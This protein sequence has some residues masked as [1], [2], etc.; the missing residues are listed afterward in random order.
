MTNNVVGFYNGAN[1]AVSVFYGFESETPLTTDTGRAS[2]GRSVASLGAAAG[3]STTS[4]SGE[5]LPFTVNFTYGTPFHIGVRVDGSA[6][7]DG[8]PFGTNG[9]SIS[10]PGGA[11]TGSATVDFGNTVTWE[12]I[13]SVLDNA[14]QPVASYTITSASGT[15]YRFAVREPARE[16]PLVAF[17]DAG[18]GEKTLTWASTDGTSYQ[19]QTT[20]DLTNSEAWEDVGSAIPATTTE[21]SVTFPFTVDASPRFWR[22]KEIAVP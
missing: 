3:S 20:T 21:T 19:L 17:V 14:S 15:D 12:G 4:Y 22:I 2:G 1:A 6:T 18:P 9:N 7:T 10:P 5:I 11:G 16:I 8:S 13:S